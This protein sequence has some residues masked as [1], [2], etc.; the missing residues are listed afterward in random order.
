M[1]G[2]KKNNPLTDQGYQMFHEFDGSERQYK[3]ISGV[4]AIPEN[5]QGVAS[6]EKV[7][8]NTIR[9]LGRDGSVIETACRVDFLQ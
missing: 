8:A 2:E 9:I 7:D 3:L 4:V 6:I 5:Y 1:A